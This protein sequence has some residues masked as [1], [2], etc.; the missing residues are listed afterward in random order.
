MHY[1]GILV[2]SDPRRADDC[3]RGVEALPGIEVHLRYPESGRLIAV[4][5]TATAGEQEAG[6]RR[7]Q[8]LPGVVFAALVHHV[9]DAETEVESGEVQG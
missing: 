3:A 9:I 2:V 1:S 8:A 5:E 7:I 6:L 4:Q